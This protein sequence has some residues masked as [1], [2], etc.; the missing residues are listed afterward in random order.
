MPAYNEEITAL[1]EQ[2]R[3]EHIEKYEAPA[4]ENVIVGFSGIDPDRKKLSDAAK[5][6]VAQL[7]KENM[8]ELSGEAIKELVDQ[9]IEASRDEL[10]S[11]ASDDSFNEMLAEVFDG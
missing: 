2:W 11:A 7:V 9:A 6:E 8:Q 5:S 3:Q 1:R 4:A 10:P